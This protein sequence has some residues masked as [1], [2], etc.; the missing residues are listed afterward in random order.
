MRTL[1]IL[2]FAFNLLFAFSD[3]SRYC[4]K[5]ELIKQS[6]EIILHNSSD[7]SRFYR[8]NGYQIYWDRDDLEEFILA[9]RDRIVNYLDIDYHQDEID[10]LMST[11][12]NYDLDIQKSIRA[13]IELLATDGFF[14]LSRDLA[15]GFIDF[16]RFQELLK[17][18]HSDVVWEDSY[19]RYNYHKDLIESLNSNMIEATLQ[20]YM[21]TS[22]GYRKLIEAYHRYTKMKLPKVDYGKL[23]RVGDYGYRAS[24]LKLYLAQTGDLRESDKGY[25]EFP[26]FDK[27][28]SDAL[29]RFQKRHYLKETGELDRVSVLYTRKDLKNKIDLIKLN[30]ERHKLFSNIYDSEY[31]VINIPEFSLR[32]FQHGVLIDNIFVVIGREDRPTPIFSD[33]LEY[34]VLNPSWGIPE[35]LVRKDY[36]FDLIADPYS[37]EKEDIFIYKITSNQH[38]QIDPSTVNWER[39]LDENIR[40][41]YYFK[42]KAGEKN[43]LGKMKF[44]FPNRYAVYL[45]DTNAKSLTTQRYRLYSSGCIRLSKPYELLN[46]LSKYTDYSYD[47]LL[48]LIES[49]KTVNIPLKKQIPIYIRY[50]TVFV[51]D[52]GDL[53]FRRD[54]Y[55]LD[56]LQLTTMRR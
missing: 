36:L 1:F 29:K 25:L 4:C 18:H 23:M 3:G 38:I 45:H 44:M 37:L 34:I 30:I 35:S 31:I 54:F 7:I 32:Y 46:I 13:R 49:K 12:D 53:S 19:K 39:Y 43:V 51:D 33:R 24:Q 56:K 41:P 52:E 5:D 42:Q 6:Q 22:K 17:E 47:R 2:F 8:S 55:T 9:T 10:R 28:L 40:I 11:I 20:S 27:K 14:S 21:P 15:E 26:T 16:K 50:F 48:D